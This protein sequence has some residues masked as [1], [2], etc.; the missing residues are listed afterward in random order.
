MGAAKLDLLPVVGRSDI[1]KMEGIVTLKGL[2][3]T[4]GLGPDDLDQKNEVDPGA[5]SG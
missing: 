2:L 1:N 3:R 5:G 4:Y